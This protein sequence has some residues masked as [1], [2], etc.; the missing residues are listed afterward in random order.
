ME[1]VGLE[2]AADRDFDHPDLPADHAMRRHVV[3]ARE[4]EA[5]LASPIAALST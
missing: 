3:Y 1:K 2:R 4:R 5:W